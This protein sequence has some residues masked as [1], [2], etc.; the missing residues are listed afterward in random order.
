MLARDE[1]MIQLNGGKNKNKSARIKGAE[2]VNHKNKLVEA[3]HQHKFD[4]REHSPR[5][6]ITACY[7]RVKQRKYEYMITL[8]HEKKYRS[9]QYDT[10]LLTLQQ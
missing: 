9:E 3:K 10:I 7:R 4:E 6:F 8:L 2:Y 1:K 5:A